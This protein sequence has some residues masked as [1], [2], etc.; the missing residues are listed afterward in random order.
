MLDRRCGAS[1]LL[2]LLQGWT[3]NSSCGYGGNGGLRKG[4][5]LVGIGVGTIR[6]IVEGNEGVELFLKVKRLRRKVIFDDR[7]NG[8]MVCEWKW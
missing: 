3:G 1:N 6:V 5:I 8:K 7:K 2:D 4:G